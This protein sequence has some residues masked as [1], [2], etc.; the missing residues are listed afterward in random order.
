[1]KKCEKCNVN[2]ATNKKQCPLCFNELEGE[3]ENAENFYS[4]APY[5][6]NTTK[7]NILLTKVFSFLTIVVLAICAF[8]NVYT[9]TEVL[10]SVLIGVGIVYVWV[11]IR[12]TILSRRGSFEKMFFQFVGLFAV[13]LTTNWLAASGEWFWDIFAPSAS[14][15]TIT[16][17]LFLLLVNKKRSD[18]VVSSFVMTIILIVISVVLVSLPANSFKLLNWINIIYS[19]LFLLAILFFGGHQLRRGLQ[20]NLHV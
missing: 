16:V 5:C 15:L 1:M 19:G 18:Y 20:K 8:I 17:L 13:V 12:H 2:V 3:G 11:L 6:D 4:D 9:G 14:L 7:K 10:W